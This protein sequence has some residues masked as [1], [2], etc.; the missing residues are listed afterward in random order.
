MV[1]VRI[2]RIRREFDDLLTVIGT[3]LIDACGTKWAGSFYTPGGRLTDGYTFQPP[4][5][6][7]C[8]L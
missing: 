3:A 7:V 2:E 1:K 6:A 8:Q 4:L 5:G